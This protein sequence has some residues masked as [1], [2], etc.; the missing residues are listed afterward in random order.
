V[1]PQR[2]SPAAV[3]EFAFATGAATPRKR[4]VQGRSRETYAAILEATFRVLADDGE[5]LTTTRVAEVAGVSV[6]TLYQYFP[7][8]EA[9][10]SGALADHLE[11]AI[12][13]V[14]AAAAASRDLPLA[15]A[16]ERIVRAFLAVK[17]ERAPVSRV[18]NRVFGA[19]K[20]DERPVVR[21]A[22]RRAQLAIASLL[23]A[24]GLPA[25]VT[26]RRAAIAC[27][28]LEGV[29]R[30]AIEDDVDRLADPLWIEQVVKVAVRAI[31]D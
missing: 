18:L 6:G 21:A 8:R 12:G 11:A 5:A 25:A 22:S 29:V 17:A 24:L 10:I 13:A 15:L 4:P 16:A 20:L 14:E 26:E 31:A 2:R 7:N 30:S 1:P 23:A 27:D 28:A 9:L 19:G 3:S